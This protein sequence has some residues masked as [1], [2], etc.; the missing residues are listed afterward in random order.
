MIEIGTLR[1]YTV[2]EAA[3][4]TKVTEDSVRTA[5]RAGQLRASKQ[6]KAYYITEA[7]LQAYVAGE[8]VSQYAQQQAEIVTLLKTI[9]EELS[10]LRAHLPQPVTTANPQQK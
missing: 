1:A 5:I 7:A 3:Q 4:L 8:D 9:R 6:G 10:A 2:K